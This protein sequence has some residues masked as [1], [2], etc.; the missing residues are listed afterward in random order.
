MTNMYN[1]RVEQG[2]WK[3]EINYF[4]ALFH[5]LFNTCNRFRLWLFFFIQFT[6]I[7]F[8]LM[9]LSHCIYFCYL[10][11]KKI[12][13]NINSFSHSS[14]VIVISPKMTLKKI[15]IKFAKTA[16]KTTRKE[17]FLLSHLIRF[18]KKKV[19]QQIL[20]R[21]FVLFLFFVILCGIVFACFV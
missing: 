2:K 21:C 20:N 19:M 10:K 3:C 17:H 9:F 18:F 1:F 5:Q 16:R 14:M 7:I 12:T 11:L 4:S 15:E 13:L 6:F 8:V